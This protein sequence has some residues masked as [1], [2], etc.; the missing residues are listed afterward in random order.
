MDYLLGRFWSRLTDFWPGRNGESGSIGLMA[1][2]G[3]L[4]GMD[5]IGWRTP[6]FLGITAKDAP[7]EREAQAW[8]RLL[9]SHAA[10]IQVSRAKLDAR[11]A[12]YAHTT[13]PQMARRHHLPSRT[14]SQ[15]H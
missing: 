1:A 8:T 6:D 14:A 12:F 9:R 2:A 15:I 5:G 11:R 10:T 3:F 4:S 13:A 7:L